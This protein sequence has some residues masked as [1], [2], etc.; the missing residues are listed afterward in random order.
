LYLLNIDVALPYPMLSV[1]EKRSGVLLR[2]ISVA[3]HH[4]KSQ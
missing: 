1:T 2:V 3:F 4:Q